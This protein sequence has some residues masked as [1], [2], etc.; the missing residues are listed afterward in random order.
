[1]K[2]SIVLPVRNGLSH[3]RQCIAALRDCSLPSCEFIVVDNESTDGTAEWLSGQQDIEVVQG[4]TNWSL[5]QS[6]NAGRKKATGE[7][8]LFLHNDVICNRLALLALMK[9]MEMDRVA[10]TGP[11]TNRWQLVQTV[12]TT[13]AIQFC[14]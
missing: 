7:L 3:T 9:V 14:G 6:F 8:L 1:M 11:L 12:R 10:A 4:Q 5:A 2:L 13:G